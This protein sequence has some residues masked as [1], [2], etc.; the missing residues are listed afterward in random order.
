VFKNAN[1]ELKITILKKFRGKIN[2]FSTYNFLCLKFAVVCQ[3]F[4]MLVEKLQ[5]PA[6]S[7]F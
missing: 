6:L 1:F 2:I 4:S 7:T 3:E 5:F